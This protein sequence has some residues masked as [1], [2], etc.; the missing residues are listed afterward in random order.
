M[1]GAGARVELEVLR[2]KR[3]DKLTA[4]LV[5]LPEPSARRP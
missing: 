5:A 2:G 3:T 1:K 4:T